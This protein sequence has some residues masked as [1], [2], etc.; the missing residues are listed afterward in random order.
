MVSKGERRIVDVV[1]GKLYRRALLHACPRRSSLGAAG[2][3]LAAGNVPKSGAG[4]EHCGSAIVTDFTEKTRDDDARSD[5]MIRVLSADFACEWM[6]LGPGHSIRSADRKNP[7]NPAAAALSSSLAKRLGAITPPQSLKK[8]NNV[9]AARERIPFMRLDTRQLLLLARIETRAIRTTLFRLRSVSGRSHGPPPYDCAGSARFHTTP[10]MKQTA[11]NDKPLLPTSS[12]ANS[13]ALHTLEAAQLL[14]DSCP[15]CGAAAQLVLPLEAG[16]FSLSRGQVNAYVSHKRAPQSDEAAGNLQRKQEDRIFNDAL[17]R[18]AQDTAKLEVDENERSRKEVQLQSEPPVPVCDRCH[19]I[20]YHNAATP[21]AAP[22]IQSI[23]ATIRQSPHTH[24]RIYHVVDAADFPLS[25][26]PNL[27]GA[28]SLP[29]M[30]TQNR[31]SKSHR[32]LHGRTAEVSFVITRSDLLAPTRK[33]ADRLLP[34]LR[35]VLRDALSSANKNARLGNVYLVS[36]KRGWW[37]KELKQQVWEAGGAGWLVGKMNVGKSSLFEVIFPKGRNQDINFQKLRHAAQPSVPPGLRDELD[38]G[39][40]ELLIDSSSHLPA[41]FEASPEAYTENEEALDGE[42]EDHLGALLPPVQAEVPYPTM[43][44]VSRLP[45]TTASPIRVPF[46]NGKGE[47]I[48]LPGMNRGNLISYIDEE[49]RDK[50]F[51]KSRIEPER[52]VLKPGQSVL[53]GG[54]VRITPVTSDQIFLVHAF[55]RLQPHVTST[56]KA[57]A[58]QNGDREV[59]SRIDHF[60]TSEAAQAY[61]SA[62]RFALKWDVTRQNAGPLVRKDAVGLKPSELPFIVY[63]ADIL[64]EG[65]GWVEMTAQVRRRRNLNPVLNGTDEDPQGEAFP[66]VEVFTPEGK[67][68][69]IRKPMNAYQLGQKPKKKATQRPRESMKRLKGQQKTKS[70]TLTT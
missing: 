51:M 7:A 22:T 38:N 6:R 47:L 40:E 28:L 25:L 67:F 52:L 27:T 12:T 2:E 49:W 58:L 69:G 1:T 56:E 32:F 23:E 63:A 8:K 45:G 60:A 59:G 48:D 43:P 30:R 11:L 21:I 37:T 29:R 62:G 26:V 57:M 68:V 20:L 61:K 17:E 31:R 24:N 33:Q 34:Y 4:G 70:Q 41:D 66:E 10:R 19:A 50:L 13:G 55:M 64:V 44:T 9:R 36:A 46:G 16:F 15:G 3:E 53:L 54:L 14:P 18:L 35:E 65:L 42:H 39:E 5:G